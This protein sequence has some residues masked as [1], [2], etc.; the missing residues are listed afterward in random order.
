MMCS[1]LVFCCMVI[2]LLIYCF[3]YV[4]LT[5]AVCWWCLDLRCMGGSLVGLLLMG[6]CRLVLCLVGG[7]RLWLCAWLMVWCLVV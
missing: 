5:L 6:G 7:L 1:H 4:N 3:C 2:V